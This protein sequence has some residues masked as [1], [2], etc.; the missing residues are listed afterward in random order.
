MMYVLKFHT[1]Y[2][3]HSK[4]GELARVVKKDYKN[5]STASAAATRIANINRKNAVRG[6]CKEFV[7]WSVC[8]A[9]NCMNVYRFEI[10]ATASLTEKSRHTMKNVQRL[11]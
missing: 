6:K 8:P 10:E 11:S 9:N 2:N 5:F 3:E 1:A 7:H 4:S